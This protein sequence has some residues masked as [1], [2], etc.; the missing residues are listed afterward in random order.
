MICWSAYITRNVSMSFSTAQMEGNPVHQSNAM[1]F[2][3]RIS[4]NAS[5][6]N[7]HAMNT[8]ALKMRLTNNVMQPSSQSLGTSLPVEIKILDTEAED[9][10][11]SSVPV[12]NQ[13]VTVTYS[14]AKDFAANYY[15]S[16]MQH[17]KSD[18]NTA[19]VHEALHDHKQHVENLLARNNA[20]Q[21]EQTL[22]AEALVDHKQHAELTE[23]KVEKIAKEFKNM[24]QKLQTHEDALSNH[25]VSIENV[26]T[27]VDSMSKPPSTVTVAARAKPSLKVWS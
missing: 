4:L 7:N 16:K 17:D 3:H 26:Q 5:E 20:M 8:S 27:K 10:G 9:R 2:M 6:K 15:A 19:H 18:L 13:P 1:P 11:N 23:A 22:H 14:N 24:R 21:Q 12:E 25:K